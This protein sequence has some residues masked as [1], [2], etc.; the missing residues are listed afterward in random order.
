MEPVII[1]HFLE[2][3][4]LQGDLFG[5]TQGP[6]GSADPAVKG[7]I[8][9]MFGILGFALLLNLFNSGVRKKLV[10]QEKL[11]RIMKETRA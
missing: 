3:V 7:M 11:Q 8:P 10:D 5:I 9:S 2:S 1:L 4:F 6:L